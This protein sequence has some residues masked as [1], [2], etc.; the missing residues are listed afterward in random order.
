ML[1]DSEFSTGAT[2]WVNFIMGYVYG[3]DGGLIDEV[4]KHV[5]V[6]F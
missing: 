6:I 2:H 3:N 4:K 1:E 5:F